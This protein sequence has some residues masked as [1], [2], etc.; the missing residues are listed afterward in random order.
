MGRTPH[1]PLESCA[2]HI[3]CHTD[4]CYTQPVTYPMSHT[5]THPDTHTRVTHPTSHIP[6]VTHTYVTHTYVTRT[7]CLTYIV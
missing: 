7:L 1:L 2:S 5:H 4:L 6:H 3:P